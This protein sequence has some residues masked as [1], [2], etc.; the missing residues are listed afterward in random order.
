MSAAGRGCWSG[1]GR[2]GRASEGS[3]RGSERADSHR[4]EPGRRTASPGRSSSRRLLCPVPPRRLSSVAGAASARK[5]LGFLD[6]LQFELIPRHTQVTWSAIAE[7]VTAPPTGNVAGLLAHLAAVDVRLAQKAPIDAGAAGRAFGDGPAV[8]VRGAAREMGPTVADRIE[9]VA[10]AV[11]HQRQ[12][13][14]AGQADRGATAVAPGRGR[15]VALQ[16][17]PVEERV[18]RVVDAHD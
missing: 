2:R 9:G 6:C 8:V 11:A 13:Q 17:V 7:D 1:C 16:R 4:P 18:L 15:V 3:R 14:L 12:A 10:V 5:I